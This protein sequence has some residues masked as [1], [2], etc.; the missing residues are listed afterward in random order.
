MMIYNHGFTIYIYQY[1][2]VILES[3]LMFL[4]KCV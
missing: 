3:Y 1:L 4:H 2:M